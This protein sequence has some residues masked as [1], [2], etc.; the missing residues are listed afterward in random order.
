M[1]K[2]DLGSFPIDVKSCRF[3]LASLIFRERQYAAR[4]QGGVEELTPTS[5]L[6]PL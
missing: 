2:D 3:V 1:G 4:H 6:F 5:F